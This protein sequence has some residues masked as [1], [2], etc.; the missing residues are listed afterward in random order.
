MAEWDELPHDEQ[1]KWLAVAMLDGWGEE[2]QRLSAAVYTA[3]GVKKKDT[4]D[5]FTADDCEYYPGYNP[6]V[7]LPRMTSEE[8][9]AHAKAVFLGW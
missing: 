7:P 3:G 4:G 6:P 5:D 8:M 1:C 2:T 9:E